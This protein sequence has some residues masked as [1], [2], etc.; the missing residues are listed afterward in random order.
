M[1]SHLL[2][3]L[4]SRGESVRA[5]IRNAAGK[6]FLEAQGVEVVIGDIRDATVA[7]K[8]IDGINVV[9]HC[10]A[11]VG[12]HCTKRE[13]Y[14][15]NLG[16]VRTLL[17]ACRGKA[18]LRIV[19]VS[20]VNVL[21]SRN[22]DPATEDLPSHYSHD[23]AADVKIE[24]EKA[25]REHAA[26]GGDIVVVRPGFV[27]GPGDRHNLPRLARA[28]VRGK[29]S[30]LGSRE[31]VVPIVYIS[32][33]VEALILAG[34]TP[35]AKGRIYNITDGSRTTIAEFATCLAEL[36]GAPPPTKRLPYAIPYL[37]C[38]FF[39][40]L[41]KIKKRKKPAPINRPAL[42]FLGTSRFVDIRRAREELGYQPRM[43]YREGMAATL[44][45]I[46]EQLAELGVQLPSAA[47][48]VE[49]PPSGGSSTESP[50]A[51]GHA[52]G[53]RAAHS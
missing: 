53:Q 33:I 8:A 52:A 16:G 42:R 25:A 24:A 31:N 27:Y 14:D 39:E 45:W 10:A 22:L 49:G 11:A 2:K 48:K 32:D 28:I 36:L 20:S 21:G 3:E 44:P 13:I 19:L 6:P 35:A 18:D 5:L 15:T 23:P 46:R 37:G 34:K 50:H 43:M 51:A 47:S 41:G 4:L 1:G 30:F 29:F 9:Q 26:Q 12:P 38:V 40:L 7:A 17:D